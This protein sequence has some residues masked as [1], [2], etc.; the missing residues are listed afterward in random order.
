MLTFVMRAR[1]KRRSRPRALC[2]RSARAKNSCLQDHLLAMTV[3]PATVPQ[4]QHCNSTR[5]KQWLLSHPRR[6]PAVQ[7]YQ[8]R[9]HREWD[10]QRQREHPNA[11]RGTTARQARRGQ[12][13]EPRTVPPCS[14]GLDARTE[15][16]AALSL[17]LRCPRCRRQRKRCWGRSPWGP[18]VPMAWVPMAYDG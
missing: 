14:T 6:G 9:R 8:P 17:T 1:Y 7:L 15:V 18:R 16:A 5:E 11:S 13:Y 2:G 4:V 12:R 3:D 10:G